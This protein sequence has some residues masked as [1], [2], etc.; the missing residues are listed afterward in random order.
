M[1]RKRENQTTAVERGKREEAVGGGGGGL[2]AGGSAARYATY[3]SSSK[4]Q[5]AVVGLVDEFISEKEKI[6]EISRQNDGTD[7]PGRGAGADQATTGR[8]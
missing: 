3:C 8:A 4:Q 6:V 2:E 5:G 7:G 1:E